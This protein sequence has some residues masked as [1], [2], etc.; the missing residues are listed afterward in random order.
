MGTSLRKQTSKEYL[1][2]SSVLHLAFLSGQLMFAGVAYFLQQSGGFEANAPE[3]GNIFKIVV[4]IFVLS[5]IV[6]S[7]F[8]FNFKVKA[9][10]E[11]KSYPRNS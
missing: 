8:L 2:T 7:Y 6:G 9:S 5:A 10:K 3:L 1:N 11:K 4:S